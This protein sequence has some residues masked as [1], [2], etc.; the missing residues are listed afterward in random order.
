VKYLLDTC[1]LSEMVKPIPHPAVVEWLTATPSDTLFISVITIGELR[2]GV[3]KLPESNKKVRLTHWLGTL[4][5]EYGDRIFPID[6]TVSEQWGVMQAA[7]E[8]AGTPVAV[9]DGLIA[10]TA[11][12]HQ[13]IVVTRN[14][15]DFLPSKVLL[16]DPW[17]S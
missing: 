6:L 14:R 3:A 7:S 15:R 9:L 1:V 11:L 17:T 5:E 2:K 10:A 13:L 16:F 12:A 4:M 8:K